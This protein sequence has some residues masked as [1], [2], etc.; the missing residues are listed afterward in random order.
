MNL[1]ILAMTG[2]MLVGLVAFDG[3]ASDTIE[4][5]QPASA[6]CGDGGFGDPCHCLDGVD[7]GGK[8]I[9]LPMNC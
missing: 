5:T 2:L 8:H 1:R 9:P 3:T 4:L 7:V 6:I